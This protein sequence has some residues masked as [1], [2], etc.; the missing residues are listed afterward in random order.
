M[1]NLVFATHN[2]HKSNE[3]KHM[4]EGLYNVI[5]LSDIG[6]NE[7]IAETGD[8]LE[9]NARIKAN[10]VHDATGFSVFADDT[11]LEID[12]L[13]GQPGVYTARFAGPEC[14]SVKNMEKVLELLENKDNRNAQ[15]RTV[16]CLI[17]GTC[18][19]LFEGVVR[20]HIATEF[21]GEEGFGYD[22]IF[23]PEGY[24]KTFA[25]MPLSEK[26]KI[27]H[28]GIAIKKLVDF[29]KEIEQKQ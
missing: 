9:A 10:F 11:G 23:I 4:L 19:F 24:N 21:N 26:N 17:I 8:T 20:G 5:D 28:R 1:S 6:I 7:D 15:F 3:V 29:L 18:E 25:E 12:A 16:I 27:S 22:P 14:D 13:D 2:T